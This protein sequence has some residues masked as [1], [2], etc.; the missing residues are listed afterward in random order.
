MTDRSSTATAKFLLHALSVGPARVRELEAKA[1]T[2]G[3]LGK[4]QSITHAKRFTCAKKTLH[5]RSVRKQFGAG[6]EWS[7]LLPPQPAPLATE[8]RSGQ[9]AAVR[10]KT[11]ASRA[12]NDPDGLFTE[13]KGRRIPK[14]WL[15]GIANFDYDRAPTTDI[16]LH[17]WRQFIND[18]HILVCSPEKLAELAMS[19]DWDAQAL[20]GCRRT[21]PL[22]HFGS[23][24][25]VWAISGGRLVEL[26]RDWALIERAEHRSLRVYHRRGP[27]AANVLPW[28]FQP[29][30][31]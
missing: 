27:N 20:F 13:L 1:R 19:L 6:G 25:L 17:R 5:I 24:G 3:L 26:H 18:C 8:R 11:H 12:P 31:I 2:A 9:E 16:P 4:S 7:W 29:H 10:A 30:D 22:D 14:D 15:N 28:M 23:A 21:R